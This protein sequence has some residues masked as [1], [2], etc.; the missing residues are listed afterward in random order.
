[1]HDTVSIS[2]LP[3]VNTRVA[4]LCT[5]ALAEDSFQPCCVMPSGDY[6]IS[7]SANGIFYFGL[8]RTKKGERA[9]D[10]L[11]IVMVDRLGSGEW[12]NLIQILLNQRMFK[13]HGP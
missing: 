13:R 2:A 12:R 11:V 9:G 3:S 8:I 5:R 4:A 1:M 6:V 7:F 10:A